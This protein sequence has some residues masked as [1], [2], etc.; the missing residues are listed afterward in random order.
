VHGSGELVRWLIEN[1]LVDE[2]TLL[3]YPLI[4]GQGARLFPDAGRDAALE[5]VE[6]RATSR[7]IM[8]QVYRP[9]GSPTYA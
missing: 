9:E 1:Q 8:L 5:L 6:S 2:I 7:G 4:V 3:T